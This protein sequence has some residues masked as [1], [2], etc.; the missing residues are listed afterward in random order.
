M[1]ILLIR[2]GEAQRG[3]GDNRHLDLGLTPRGRTQAGGM[4][5][6]LA[7]HNP[8]D[9]FLC[10][11]LLRARQTAKILAGSLSAPEMQVIEALCEIG[12]SDHYGTE[13]L[14]A[15]FERVRGLMTDLSGGSN[16]QTVLAVT[17]AGFIM[18]SVRSLFDIP[19]PGTGARLDPFY[20]SLTEWGFERGV[21]TLYTYSLIPW[22]L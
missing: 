13:T 19:T 17:H 21:W 18:A 12:E 16:N 6:A 2:H 5:R 4:A 3:Q 11:P 15:F 8:I 10:S 14:E 9:R 20:A 22:T 7:R 1:R